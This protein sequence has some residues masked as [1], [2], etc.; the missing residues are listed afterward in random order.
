MSQRIT[1]N[2]AES[3][4]TRFD[5]EGDLFLNVTYRR[6]RCG[7]RYSTPVVWSGSRFTDGFNHGLAGRDGQE[8]N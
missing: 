6:A 2:Q 1:D 3:C 7:W 5:S 4:S 8:V